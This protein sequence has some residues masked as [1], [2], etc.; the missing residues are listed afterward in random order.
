[1]QRR[2]AAILAADVAGYSRLMEADE[3]GTL[4]RLKSLYD[5][6][7]LPTIA[8]H[9]GRLV[10]LMGDGLLA[11]FSSAVDAVRC[12]IAVQKIV[13]EQQAL[14][15]ENGRLVFRMG[16]NLDNVIAEEN[17]IFGDSVNVAARLEGMAEPG[18]VL[19]S[20]SAHDD[21]AAQ[22]DTVFFDNGLRKFKNISR[23]IRVW[24]WPRQLP[25]L[26]AQGKP[27]VFVANF[28]GRS[29]EEARL[30]ADLS[31]G[32]KAHFARLT[33]LEVATDRAQAHYVV[34][35][36][37]RLAAN[38]SRVVAR[39]AALEA[40]RQIWS[41]RYDEDTDDPFEIVDRC[42]PRIA[43]S[44]RRHIASDDAARLANRPPDELSFEELLTHA[45]ASFFV[46]TRSGWHKGGK[47]AEQALELNPK[48]FMALAMAAAGEGLA[49]YLYSLRKPDEDVTGL[50]FKRIEGALRLNARSDMANAVHA[51][52]LLYVRKRH[53]D[54]A[55]SARRALEFNPEYNMGL[56]TLGA[57]Q[58][59]SGE[60]DAG[61]Q[62]A[63][64]AV[65]LDIRDP[66]VHLYSRIAAYG[67]L[68][69]GRYDQ[70]AEWFLRADQL[71][72]GVPPNLAGLV[73]S[74][75]VAGDE[76]GA[77]HAF[78]RLL[79]EDPEFRLREL[80]PLPYNDERNWERFVDTLRRAGA[81]D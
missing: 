80:H 43:T 31:D 39:L 81:P 41:E 56:W 79:E 9:R 63:T 27:R 54:A 64:R 57:I 52:L 68:G 16:V 30:G 48:S 14:V 46:P 67:H 66:Y 22:L 34:Q 75:W 70:A 47:I 55:A 18:G 7:V 2:L 17:D 65:Q 21:V 4:A 15:P 50:A 35:G 11:E 42:T 76:E 38:R 1:M 5:G 51:L 36:S 28:E 78:L 25:S 77:R 8:E 37:L 61:A 29:P 40:D 33:G 73:V 3:A 10:K 23:A 19:I 58:V 59:F 26:R 53:R 60:S 45:G 6:P 12:C 69:A 74:R 72:P 24:S 32:I 44:I 71:A 62:S 20:Q 13:A 49:D